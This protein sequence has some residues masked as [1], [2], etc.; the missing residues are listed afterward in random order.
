MKGFIQ[1]IGGLAQ[2]LD[3]AKKAGIKKVLIPKDNEKEFRE[4][5]P[6][7]YGAVNVVTVSTL[8]EALKEIGYLK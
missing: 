8:E 5:P 6:Q 2:K 1:G 4:L 7:V 3:A